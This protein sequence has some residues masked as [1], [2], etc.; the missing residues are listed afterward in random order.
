MKDEQGQDIRKIQR[1][2]NKAEREREEDKVIFQ[3]QVFYC[4]NKRVDYF[5]ERRRSRLLFGLGFG[6]LS[7]LYIFECKQ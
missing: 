7:I 6:F 1:E 4:G 2:R 3:L 5:L